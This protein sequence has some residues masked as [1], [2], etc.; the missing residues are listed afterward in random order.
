MI[1]LLFVFEIGLVLLL[2][3]A[4]DISERDFLSS[5][6]LTSYF[7]RRLLYASVT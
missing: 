4:V 2:K 7:R 5:C 3:I 6:E 1:D